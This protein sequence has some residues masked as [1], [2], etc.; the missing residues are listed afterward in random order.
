MALL[1]YEAAL[2]ALVQRLKGVC[3]DALTPSLPFTQRFASNQKLTTQHLQMHI[4]EI[5]SVGIA[6]NFE[7]GKSAKQYEVMVELSCHVQLNGSNMGNTSVKLERIIHSLEGH[8]GVYLKHFPLGEISFL[9]AGSI[10]RRDFPLDKSQWEERSSVMLV[11]SM[12]VI[13]SDP[14]DVG[15]IETVEINKLRVKDSP[16]HVAVETEITI[17]YP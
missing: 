5:D 6:D 10:R 7:Y 15:H 11:F 13:M 9:R 2:Q 3:D 14:V 17:T 12:M 16:S 4:S 8:T 1:S